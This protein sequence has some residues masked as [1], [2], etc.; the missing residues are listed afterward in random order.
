MHGSPLLIVISGP[1][2][3]GKSRLSQALLE[4]FPQLRFSVSATTRPP[5]A[6]ELNG[7]H[8]FFVSEQEFLARVAADDFLEWAKVYGNY[9]GTLKSHVDELMAAGY[10]VL[11]DIDTQGAL[12]IKSKC[13]QGVFVFVVPPSPQ[14]LARRIASRGTETPESMAQ[15]LAG[16]ANEL[17]HAGAYDYIVVND[18]VEAAVGRLASI[19]VAERCRASRQDLSWFQS[20][21]QEGERR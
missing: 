13:P 16:A 12:Q 8:Y 17:A 18:E 1:S 2:G 21:G 6:G 20:F 9:Y 15:R 4:R 14:E 10:D 11:L 19:I 3:A 7:V 5:R